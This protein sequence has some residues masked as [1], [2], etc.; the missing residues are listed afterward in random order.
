MSKGLLLTALVDLYGKRVSQ[1]E[2]DFPNECRAINALLKGAWDQPDEV[3]VLRAELAAV[4]AEKEALVRDVAR[5]AEEGLARLD[6]LEQ[7]QRYCR[8]EQDRA[9]TERTAERECSR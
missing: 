5:Q 3:D 4:R 6:Q 8:G 7:W 1:L 9:I 2:L